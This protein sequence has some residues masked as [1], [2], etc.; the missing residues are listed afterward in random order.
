MA[1]VAAGLTMAPQLGAAGEAEANAL[2]VDA[3]LSANQAKLARDAGNAAGER[4]ALSNAVKLLDRILTEEKTSKIA[5]MLAAGQKIGSF[6]PAAVR[7]RLKSL[8]GAGAVP[9]AKAG[10]AVPKATQNAAPNVAPQ[11]APKA[12]TNPKPTIMVRPPKLTGQGMAVQT[13]LRNWQC[14]KNAYAKA[15][16]KNGGT[17]RE[18]MQVLI[19]QVIR[20]GLTEGVMGDIAAITASETKLSSAVMRG[21]RFMVIVTCRRDGPDA[22]I[23]A[24]KQIEDLFITPADKPRWRKRLQEDLSAVVLLTQPYDKTLEAL[25]VFERAGYLEDAGKTREKFA[26]NVARKPWTELMV[27]VNDPTTV[28][29]LNGRVAVSVARGAAFIGHPNAPAVFA[30]AKKAIDRA[31]QKTGRDLTKLTEAEVVYALR[32]GDVTRFRTALAKLKARAVFQGEAPDRAARNIVRLIE[33][34]G[35][36]A[37]LS[38]HDKIAKAMAEELA[39]QVDEHPSVLERRPADIWTAGLWI[40]P[41]LTAK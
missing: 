11:Q 19:S 31:V 23:K 15:E 38:P 40:S 5:V 28:A 3:V 33:N 2:L 32:V 39:R 35:P 30:N 9:M 7:V 36:F 22:S 18:K 25:K 8:G 27:H 14:T 16:M 26:S 4:K 12:V 29:G 34:M 6:D 37:A 41:R 21:M 13:C 1:I 20:E 10:N 17:A 24:L